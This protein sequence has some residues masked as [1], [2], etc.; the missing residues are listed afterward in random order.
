M[1]EFISSFPTVRPYTL[2][3]ERA[4]KSAEDAPRS[5]RPKTAITTEIIW[6]L[7]NIVGEDL[8]FTKRE[9][10][11]TI[12]ISDKREPHISHQELC[13]RNCFH[14]LTIKKYIKIDLSHT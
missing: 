10:A 11:D 8:S 14:S 12:N 13:M 7:H 2:D 9:I 3:I 6:Q 1:K 5:R 4:H